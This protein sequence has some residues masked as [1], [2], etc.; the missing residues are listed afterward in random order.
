MTHR[1]GDVPIDVMC[2]CFC[3]Y[4]MVNWHPVLATSQVFVEIP[5]TRSINYIFLGLYNCQIMISS[6]KRQFDVLNF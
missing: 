4:S 2:C 5:I 6:V 1:C 3:D